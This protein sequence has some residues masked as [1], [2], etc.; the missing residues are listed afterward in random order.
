MAALIE[1]PQEDQPDQYMRQSGLYV[2]QS[3]TSV[4]RWTSAHHLIAIADFPL[5]LF[6]DKKLQSGTI[7]GYKPAISDNQEIHP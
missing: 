2:L 5:Y 4:I 7:D 1:A 6:Q 3:G